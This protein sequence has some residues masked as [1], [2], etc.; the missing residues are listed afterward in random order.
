MKKKISLVLFCSLLAYVWVDHSRQASDVVGSER[1]YATNAAS[2]KMQAVGHPTFASPHASPIRLLD[3][4]VF[5][6][7]TPSDTVDVINAD[8]REITERIN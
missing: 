7:N 4:F 8:T 3:R 1:V 2:S 6:V 5:V